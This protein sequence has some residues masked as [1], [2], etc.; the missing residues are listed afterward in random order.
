[1]LFS[2]FSNSLRSY[3]WI[4]PFFVC[5]T[6]MRSHLIPFCISIANY[7]PF[8][9]IF[10]GSMCY[11]VLYTVAAFIFGNIGNMPNIPHHIYI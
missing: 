6:Y 4:S 10:K 1:M 11:I 3:P 2:F 7:N 9:P 8:S 5:Q